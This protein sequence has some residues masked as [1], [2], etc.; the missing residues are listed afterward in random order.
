M[1]TRERI[2]VLAGAVVVVLL[3][4]LVA[5]HI[6]LFAAVPNFMIAFCMAMAVV[7]PASYGCIL[8]FVLGL[9][10]DFVGGGPVGA[11][12]FSLTAFSV[13]VSRVFVRVDNDS[14]FM[15]FALM[16]VGVLLIHVSYAAFLAALGFNASLGE[17]L[18]YRVLPCFVYDTVLALI[19][20]PIVTRLARPAGVV[21][22]ELTQLR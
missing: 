20:Y 2:F 12:A 16:A 17:M 5:P 9:V 19:M 13:I 14:L 11:M 22:T 7:H 1:L 21:R 6:G 15:A 3:Q 4:L 8:P 18:V 10:F